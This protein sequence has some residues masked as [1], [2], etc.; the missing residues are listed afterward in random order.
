VQLEGR[1][2][3]AALVV[4]VALSAC[5]RGTQTEMD[6][7]TGRCTERVGAKGPAPR[8]P[9]AP[10]LRPGFGGVV[11]TLADA[12]GALSNYSILATGRAGSPGTS[13]ARATADSAGGFVFD[14]L[15]PGKY[16]ISVRP[17]QH[18]PD[19]TDIDVAAG[20]ID[21]VTLRPQYYQCAPGTR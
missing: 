14:R 11:G 12:G 19:S 21:T 16:R 3:A 17:V 5:H 10:S 1:F 20:R 18:R 13:N 2:R 7:A 8:L 9:S 4:A 15:T 6:L